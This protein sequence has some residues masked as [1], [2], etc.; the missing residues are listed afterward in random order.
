MWYNQATNCTTELIQLE[1]GSPLISFERFIPSD[2]SPIYL[3]IITYIKQGL[4]AGIFK[5]GD[6][7]PS[8]RAL[9]ALLGVNPNTVQKSYH[10]LEEEGIISS[11]QGAKSVIIADD[12]IVAQLKNQLVDDLSKN[13]IIA[14]KHMNV[15]KEAALSAA[16]R[17][18]DEID[19][20]EDI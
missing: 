11:A 12:S 14:L 7:I 3:Q 13:Y 4:A 20:K 6:E 19:D 5:K 10:A 18:W 2:N 15:S 1:G 17:L 8:R 9:S 16:S